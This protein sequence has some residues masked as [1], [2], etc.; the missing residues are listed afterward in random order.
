MSQPPKVKPVR[1]KRSLWRVWRRGLLAAFG[2]HRTP[3]DQEISPLD[4]LEPESRALQ[5]VKRRKPIWV[6]IMK[7]LGSRKRK[8][9]AAGGVVV[10]LAGF[11]VLPA[12]SARSSLGEGQ[13]A[14]ADAQGKLSEGDI[15][16]AR[17]AF[18]RAQEAFHNAN[19]AAGNILLRAEGAIPFI[20]RTPDALRR[21]TEIGSDVSSAG[22]DVTNGITQLPDGLES[23]APQRGR[24][25]LS[26]FAALQPS[27]GSALVSMEHANELAKGISSSFVLGSISDAG[28]DVRARLSDAV[29]LVRATDEL[30]RGVPTFAGEGERRKYFVAAQNPAE[31]RGTGGL[32]GEFSVLTIDDG[33]LSLAR[34]RDIRVLTKPAGM[35]LQ[36]PPD[37]ADLYGPAVSSEWTATNMMPDV[38]TAAAVLERLWAAS[39]PSRLDGVIYID[40]GALPFLLDASGP[41]VS[42]ELDTTLTSDNV[43]EF[44]TNTAYTTFSAA[45]SP[46]RKAAL[47]VAALQIWRQFLNTAPADQALPSLVSAAASGHIMMQAT[48][49]SLQHAFRTAG[50]SG[51][52]RYSG[53]DFVGT[54]VN[55]AVGNKLDY[56]MRRSMT[57]D[58][59]LQPGGS[60][61]AETTVTFTNTAPKGRKPNPV[62]A[63]YPYASQTRGLATGENYSLVT[64][65]F[66]PGTVLGE[67]TSDG[68]PAEIGIGAQGGLTL[69]ATE[70]KIKPQQHVTLSYATILPDAWEGDAAHGE[71]HLR[72]QTPAGIQPVDAKVIIRLPDGTSV[73]GSSPETKVNDSTVSWSGS[74]GKWSDVDVSF[75]KPF[76]TRTWDFLKKPAITW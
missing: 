75:G 67:V 46:E 32:I 6:L 49:P 15:A 34:F 35:A 20:G 33:K 30:L 69:A 23:L 24:I 54:S 45:R 52:F 71:Y 14:L 4:V 59:T 1:R 55:N 38:P 10:F 37:L 76:L 19:G 21:L 3:V 27:I 64:Q 16:G 22:L 36:A 41:V 2:V 56:Y 68:R 66:P 60:A 11:S 70:L 58:V 42:K 26:A 65:Y 31:A 8:L 63:P 48:D 57:Y 29:P 39:K 62:T 43:V 73:S 5:K 28:Q 9:V 12:L 7:D 51:E 40:P 74:V 61:T 44:T 47:G 50:I 25:S 18:G 17:A 13:A 72:L 53:G